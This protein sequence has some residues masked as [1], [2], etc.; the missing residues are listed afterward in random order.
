MEIKAST[1]LG[2]ERKQGADFFAKVGEQAGVPGRDINNKMVESVQRQAASVRP[3]QNV[4]QY[5]VSGTN[6]NVQA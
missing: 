2:F 4:E 5:Q 1:E 6:V 3:S